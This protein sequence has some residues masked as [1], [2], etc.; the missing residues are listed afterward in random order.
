MGCTRPVRILHACHHTT[1]TLPLHG[2]KSSC[3]QQS[4]HPATQHIPLLHPWPVRAVPC[5]HTLLP[6]VKKATLRHCAPV[7]LQHVPRP[8]ARQ[9]VVDT[10]ACRSARPQ[11]TVL[12]IIRVTFL[13][14][15]LQ[16]CS[17]VCSNVDRFGPTAKTWR[18]HRSSGVKVSAGSK[19]RSWTRMGS[20][21]TAD[22]AISGPFSAGSE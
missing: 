22:N 2:Q 16:L 7:G 13:D 12:C 14:C 9:L 5:A 15:S 1:L 21:F 10:S 20:C 6:P 18:A 3:A 8:A 4:T 17:N 11:C 19:S